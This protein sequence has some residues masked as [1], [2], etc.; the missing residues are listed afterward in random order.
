M[1]IFLNG[2]E[3]DLI[4]NERVTITKQI[5]DL[6][7]VSR[8]KTSYTNNFKILKTAKNVQIMNYLGVAG[9]QSQIQFRLNNVTLI[10]DSIVLLAN[11]Y[12]V[13]EPTEEKYYNLNLFGSEKTFFERLKNITLKEAY[14]VTNIN[15]SASNLR[16]YI[17]SNTNFCFPVMQYSDGTF[18]SGAL[19][20]SS[21]VFTRTPAIT[22]TPM[23][24]ARFM[25][26]RIFS[27]LGYTVSYPIANDAIFNKLMFPPQKGVSHFGVMHGD[28]FNLQNCQREDVRCDEFVR[29]IMWRFGMLIQV[30][31]FDKKVTFTKIDE[32]LKSAP[33][34]DWTKN[35][36]AFKSESYTFDNYA[37]KNYF[38]YSE[39]VA[40]ETFP[41]IFPA[42]QLQGSFTIGNETLNPEYTVIESKAQKPKIW[43][44]IETNDYAKGRIFF[45]NATSANTQNFLIDV[46]ENV[47]QDNGTVKI[48]EVPFQFFYLRNLGG[49]INYSFIQPNGVFQTAIQV[50]SRTC[51]LDNISFQNY[52]DNHY[53][54]FRNLL[55]NVNILKAT[56]NL[57]VLDFYR[58]NLFSRVYLEQFGSY[59]YVNKITNWQKGKLCE[60][61]LVK[62]PP[63]VT[64]G[65]GGYGYSNNNMIGSL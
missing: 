19:Q 33:I 61:E 22:S 36:S 13:I 14:P 46:A 58:F 17:T 20:T 51:S 44:Y 21:S 62:I 57:S 39:D 6:A 5:N 7:D 30:D 29:E 23:F 34:V 10:E 45:W 60:V 41:S 31:E 55:N 3:L 18:H 9:N 50:Q 32:L 52:L 53:I 49:L 26:E 54:Q 15:W 12:A 63:L 37:Q 48:K 27:H 59:Y 11:G 47:A 16:T 64:S 8:A 38:K 56:F 1:Q 42:E 43:R 24:F 4:G 40:D 2:L 25:F 35:F 28:T 65:G